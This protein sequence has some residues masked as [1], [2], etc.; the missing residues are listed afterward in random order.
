[1]GGEGGITKCA[2]YI[3]APFVY[4]RAYGT[5]YYYLVLRYGHRLLI[6]QQQYEY[7]TVYT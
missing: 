1:M 4:S 7:A 5:Y 3:G 6:L 2:P